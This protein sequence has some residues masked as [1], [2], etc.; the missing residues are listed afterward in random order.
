MNQYLADI[1]SQPEALRKAVSTLDFGKL[2]GLGEAMRRGEFDRIVLTGMGASFYGIYPAWLHLAAGGL[3][4]MWVDTAELIHHT[5]ALVGE[6]TL[7]WATS[8]S[9]HSAEIVGLVR[10][11]EKRPPAGLIVLTND[12]SSP[13]GQAAQKHQAESGAMLLLNAEPE[14]APSTRTYLNTLAIG[15]LAALWLRQ[16]MD[17]QID[18]SQGLADLEATSRGIEAYLGE[19]EHRL[20]QLQEVIQAGEVD[21][22]GMPLAIVLMGRGLSLASAYAGALNLQEAAKLPALGIQAGEFRH[23]PLEIAR[24]G[25]TALIFGGKGRLDG[26]ILEHPDVEPWKLNEKLWLQLQEMGV[27]AWL[28]NAGETGLENQL[29]MPSAAGIGLPLAEIVPIQL[30]CIYLSQQAG[31]EP[32]AFRH[33][34]KVTEQE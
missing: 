29:D 23:G 19:W 14:Q 30:L 15:Q 32:G 31:L 16:A 17:G 10:Q 7:L 34:G 8:Q 20:S 22:R 21:E 18:L 12:A 27:N 2:T 24:P 26:P 11:I 33:I 3:P 6:R 28:V 25:L 1:L 5:P 13:L 9:G 4:A